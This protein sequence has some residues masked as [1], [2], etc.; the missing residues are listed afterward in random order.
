M[1][2]LA[3]TKTDFKKRNKVIVVIVIDGGNGL[4]IYKFACWFTF[5]SRGKTEVS[6]SSSHQ[7]VESD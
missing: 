7:K 6:F 3:M 1:Q 2:D 5:L 4:N